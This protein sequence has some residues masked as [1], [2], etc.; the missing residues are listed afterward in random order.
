MTDISTT[1]HSISG[2]PEQKRHP[3][4]S[5]GQLVATP[6]ALRTLEEF[7]VTPLSLIRRHVTGGW[8]DLCP[9]D[10]RA[11]IVAIE[12]GGRIFSSYKLTRT[13]DGQTIE[14]TVWCI[15]DCTDGTIGGPRACTT[16]LLPNEY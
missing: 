14:A 4:F 2:M 1:T 11:N 5:L 12:D 3:L 7:G 15:A 13:N 16:F 10:Q 6:G 9:E 8:G